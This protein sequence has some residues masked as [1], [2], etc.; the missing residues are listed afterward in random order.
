MISDFIKKHLEDKSERIH[1]LI[2]IDNERDF[3]E[4]RI[5]TYIAM[6]PET[7]LRLVQYLADLDALRIRTYRTD[8]TV[9]E[10]LS[11]YEANL[12]HRDE[13]ESQFEA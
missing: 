4:S 2:D 1:I 5:E 10:I 13:N 9:E 12:I 8:I 6:Q 11:G 3:S 7:K